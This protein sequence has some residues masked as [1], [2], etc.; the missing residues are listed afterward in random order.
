MI[1]IGK[2]T[3]N[4]M[5]LKYENAKSRFS[6]VSNFSVKMW[7]N[8]ESDRLPEPARG[9][10]NGLVRADQGLDLAVRQLERLLEGRSRG[11]AR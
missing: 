6:K 1:R 4:F 5:E 2:N 8:T 9:Q 7:E 11:G 3:F 10:T